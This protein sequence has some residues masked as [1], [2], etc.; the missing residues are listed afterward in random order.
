MRTRCAPTTPGRARSRRRKGYSETNNYVKTIL[1][2]KDPGQL[3]RPQD[4][5]R[6][7]VAARAGG[8]VGAG[9]PRA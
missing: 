6:T 9:A 2:G 3:N 5:T 7:T 8:P 4:P 1:G